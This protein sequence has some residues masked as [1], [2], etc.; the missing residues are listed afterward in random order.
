VRRAF[1]LAALA[2]LIVAGAS[3]A[4]STGDHAL[5]A[6][7]ILPPG[8]GA[9][10]PELTNQIAMYDGLTPLQGNVTA[11]DLTKFYKPETLGLGGAKATHTVKPKAG[12]TIYRDSFGVPHVY[13]KTRA[14]TEF[15]AGWATAEDRGLYLQL[16]RGAARISALDVPGYDAFSVALSART[17]VPSAQTEAF[18][19]SQAKLAAQTARGRQLLKDVDAYIAGINAYFLKA[20]G[21]VKPYTRNDVTAIGT[22]IGAVFGAGGGNEARSG[23]F[24]SALQQKLGAAKGLSVWND[25]RE[26]MDSETPVTISTPFPYDNGPTGIGAG[27]VPIDA[28][29]FQPVVAGSGPLQHRQLMSN[30]LLVGA[31]RSSNGHPIFVAGPQVGYYSPEILMELDLHG[32]GLNAR[33]VAFPGLG[34]YLQIGRAA[35]YAWSATSAS[36]DVIDEFAETLCGNGATQY[37]YKGQCRDMGTF[38]AGTL[39]GQNGAQDTELT[40]HTTVHGPVVGYATSGGKRVAISL[41]RSTR[42]RELLAAIPF[43]VLSTGGVH[44][45]QQFFDTMSK[46]DLTFNWFYADSKHIAMYS[47]GRLPLRSPGVNGGLPTNGNGS[48]EWRGWLGPMSHP[49]VVDPKSGQIVNWNNKPAAAFGAADDNWSYGSVHRVDL[50][51]TNVGTK[52]HTPASVVSAMNAAATKDLRYT[53][54]NT[55]ADVM[56][57]GTAP[58]ARATQMLGLL[59]KWN[60]SR[61]DANGD[62]KIDDPGAAIMDAWWPK[63]AVADLQPVL[64]NLTDDLKQL[65]S[66]SNDAN[67]NGS[68]YGSGWYSY[69]DKDLRSVLGDKV[70]S[71]YS[72]KFCGLG[73]VATCAAQLWASLDAAGAELAA[74]QGAD[75]SLWRAD[76][77]KERIRF[78]GFIPDTMRW[79]NRP[80]FQQVVVFR[81]HR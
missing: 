62:G 42:G 22:L 58:S 20:G 48:Y 47:S 9:N 45:P 28:G 38:D 11:G 25:L 78:A 17:F 15:G 44:S 3:A 4:A 65:A 55:L 19:S 41:D 51:N 53:L 80:T 64:G 79:T 66:I 8:Q 50:L 69:V 67:P 57:R 13:G 26:H 77:T 21:F 49:H 7:N 18:L 31:K 39:K 33:G 37:S 81:S 54:I 68:S 34:F 24:L 1:P 59:G 30:A 12:V 46:F 5:L 63:L 52:K 32:G 74:A 14:D 73:V 23:Q 29:S 16:L 35:D 10:T 2:V 56:S 60:G 71:P 75:P 43:Q 70:T 36:S 6:L 27:N 72:V 40:Y 76:A 61:L